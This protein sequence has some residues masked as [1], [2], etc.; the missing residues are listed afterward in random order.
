L[1][2]G[3]PGLHAVLAAALLLGALVAA[4]GFT[5]EEAVITI[6]PDGVARA[7]LRG[8]V[9]Q[10]LNEVKL[11]ADPIIASIV[12][13]VNGSLVAAFYQNGT[14]YVPSP[15][16]GTL[17]VEYIVD[18]K[19]TP[20]SSWFNITAT[21]PVR[22][23]VAPNIILIGVPQ[24]IADT[25]VEDGTLI[26]VVQGPTII[27]YTV[28]NVTVRQAQNPQEAQAPA[29]EETTSL[30]NLAMVILLGALGAGIALTGLALA[31]RNTPKPPSHPQ[32]QPKPTAQEQ[33]ATTPPPSTE[34]QPEAEPAPDEQLARLRRDL[35]STDLQILQFLDDAGG[36]AYQADVG[37]VLGLPK[38]TLSRRVAKL[39]R[40][41]LIRVEKEGK[42]NKL[43]L[44]SEEWKTLIQNNG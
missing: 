30:A 23:E 19:V 33:Q 21:Y 3:R 39:S 5:P 10:G 18:V 35:D 38:A 44:A 27:N 16:P 2:V 8:S 17:E 12:A 4:A 11:P 42:L 31:R 36:E 24:G 43:I 15:G 32:P 7:Y 25:L 1:E 13:R 40:L 6:G 14:L 41:G 22:V 34:P 28:T 26:L 9:D 37:R 20:A 29:Q